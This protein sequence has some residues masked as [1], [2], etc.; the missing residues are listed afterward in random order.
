MENI[1][2]EFIQWNEKE[3]TNFKSLRSTDVDMGPVSIFGILILANH[4]FK[5]PNLLLLF[6]F[7]NL[8]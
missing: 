3:K 8:L 7:G 6:P 5:A 2:A 1:N 4:L